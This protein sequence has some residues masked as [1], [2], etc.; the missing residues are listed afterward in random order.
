MEQLLHYRGQEARS[1]DLQFIKETF[2]PLGP[3][4]GCAHRP[5]LAGT[6]HRLSRGK[7]AGRQEPLPGTAGMIHAKGC[8]SSF[9]FEDISSQH[10]TVMAQT[11]EITSILDRLMCWKERESELYKQK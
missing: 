10:A 6:K 1:S 8:A 3:R 7:A 9:G 11:S 4:P 2:F 5:C